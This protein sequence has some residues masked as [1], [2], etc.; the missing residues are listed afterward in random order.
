MTMES[1]DFFVTSDPLLEEDPNLVEMAG[2]NFKAYNRADFSSFYLE[3]SGCRTETTPTFRG[4]AAK[5]QKL[6]LHDR[7]V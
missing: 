5:F 2:Y 3:S 4:Q 1:D 7:S 6:Y